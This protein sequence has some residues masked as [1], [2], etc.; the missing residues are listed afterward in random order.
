MK[1]YDI[2][3]ALSK[4]YPGSTY[5]WS[6]IGNKYE[7]IVWNGNQSEKPTEA[8]LLAEV[9]RMQSEWDNRDYARQRAIAYPPIADQLDMIFH[10]GIDAW[11]EEI[12]KVKTLFPKS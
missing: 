10:G 2:V 3:H 11:K 7:D 12:N 5:S 1:K 4:L 6:V 9:V 8:E